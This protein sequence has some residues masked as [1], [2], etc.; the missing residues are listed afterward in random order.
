MIKRFIPILLLFLII[1]LVSPLPHAGASGLRQ[2]D[3]ATLK[4]R[5]MLA[6]MTP[7]ERVGQ[8]FLVGFE[9][10]SAEQD[11][12]IYDLIVRYHVAGVIL[13]AENDNFAASPDTITSAYK[14]ISQLQE[15]EWKASQP[16][17]KSQSTET[18]LPYPLPTSAPAN[19]IPLF[20]GI[21]QGG[22]GY[23]NDQILNGLTQLPSLMAIGATWDPTIAEQV[24][25]IEGQEL[26]ALGFN[27][28][29]GP[30]L[31]VLESPD[32]SLGN[33]VDA[34][35][36]G[37]NPYWV[38]KMGSAYI[39]GLH[40]GS[41]GKLAVIANHF[42]GRGNA[43]RSAG[44][45]TATVR[46]PLDQL[47]Q[48]ELAPFFKVTGDAQTAQDL[49]DG[50][51]VSHVRYQGFQGNIRTTTRPI[52]FDPQALTQVLSLPALSSWREAGGLLV[53]DDLGSTT[54]RN[55]YDPSGK[56]FLA[57]LICF[58]W[59]TLFPATPQIIIQL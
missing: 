39:N 26:S 43:D 1:L 31:D 21:S 10:S 30:S 45:E 4:A 54:V 44:Q 58:I 16:P 47:K 46:T 42:P 20:V 32:T 53:S 3:Q 8:L 18:P 27:F 17:T 6:Q 7:D 35:S 41:D 24:G 48:I 28:L 19:Y 38:G 49:A 12:Q 23:P 29:I 52:S 9:G 50:L 57:R 33:G 22:D 15:A 14:L 51:L 25:S 11:S 2:D 40:T 56:S 59:E 34:N 37:G 5:Q 13:Q 55:F 36:F